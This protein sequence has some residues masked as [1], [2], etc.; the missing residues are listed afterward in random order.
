MTTSVSEK[1]VQA[2][3]RDLVM[4]R[5][6]IWPDKTWGNALNA[7]T[8]DLFCGRYW[9]EVKAPGKKLRPSQVEWF[10]RWVD[11]GGVIAYVCDDHR[12]LWDIIGETPGTKP[13]N[14]RDFAPK[15]HHRTVLQHALN[16]WGRPTP[17]RG[18]A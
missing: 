5:S 13:S 10:E 12:R 11:R 8:P 2:K 15:V 9:I 16:E 4:V 7:G 14:W 3:I 6:G 17:L 18:R 1:W